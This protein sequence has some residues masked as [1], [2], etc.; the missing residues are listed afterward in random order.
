VR[1]NDE[2]GDYGEEEKRHFLLPGY[3][4]EEVCEGQRKAEGEDEGEDRFYVPSDEADDEGEK[5]EGDF[6]EEAHSLHSL[7]LNARDKKPGRAHLGQKRKFGW[8]TLCFAHFEQTILRHEEQAN[9]PDFAHSLHKEKLAQKAHKAFV[10]PMWPQSFKTACSSMSEWCVP[11]SSTPSMS[12]VFFK[13]RF[14]SGNFPIFLTVFFT[15][16]LFSFFIFLLRASAC[17]Y[18]LQMNALKKVC[19]LLFRFW[20]RRSFCKGMKGRR[21]KRFFRILC[22]IQ[23]GFRRRLRIRGCARSQCS[24]AYEA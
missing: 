19:I 18:A 12:T 14:F 1:H 2:R 23:S 15:L 22:I 7:L 8:N 11:C 5:L 13:T 20:R 16:S 24:D 17:R 21:M 4:L 3:A 9:F 10:S 6:E